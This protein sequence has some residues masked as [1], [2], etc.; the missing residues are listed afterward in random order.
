M[1]LKLV[2]K[3]PTG[4]EWSCKLVQVHRDAGPIDDDPLEG[5]FEE[6]ELWMRD[7]VACI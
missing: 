7:P 5:D 3:L 2:D 4:P 1:F 6:L